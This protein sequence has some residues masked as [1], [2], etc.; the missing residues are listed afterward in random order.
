MIEKANIDTI[1]KIISDK[2]ARN[3]RQFLLEDIESK[4]I[5]IR[6][7]LQRIAD[8]TKNDAQGL[9]NDS[10]KSLDEFKQKAE[11]KRKDYEK[12]KT[13][14]EQLNSIMDQIETKTARQMENICSQLRLK[15][16]PAYTR[17]KEKSQ[18][19]FLRKL[20]DK[21]LK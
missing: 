11:A 17:P 2:L 9:L 10:Q 4:F 6:H 8:D 5:G 7:D 20:A 21:Y 15:V 1:K 3:Y 18:K 13:V 16:N 12:I 14:S 19:G